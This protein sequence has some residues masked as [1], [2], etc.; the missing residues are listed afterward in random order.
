MLDARGGAARGLGRHRRLRRDRA[1]PHRRE[2][3]HAALLHRPD[4]PRRR[5]LRAAVAPSARP[6]WRR[7]RP[8]S[9]PAST[10]IRTETA[11]DYRAAARA[12]A[13]A[14]AAVRLRQPR[15]RRRRRR[16]AVPLRRRHRRSL[17]AHG[18]GGVLG[19]QAARQRLRRRAGRGR[20]GARRAVSTGA[21]SSP[22]GIRCAPT[23]KAR[24]PPA[25]TPFSSPPASTAT[26]PWARASCRRRSLQCCSPRLRPAAMAVH[27]KARW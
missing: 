5:D 15:P 6:R 23:S 21:A 9:A 27:G 24:K 4:R 2:G 1:A 16:A 14:P 19:R 3:L 13:G 11:D 26:R 7:R 12:R 25:S 8:S 17:R 22:S 20:G 10:T 18:R